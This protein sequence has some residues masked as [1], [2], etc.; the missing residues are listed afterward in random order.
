MQYSKSLV[1]GMLYLELDGGRVDAKGEFTFGLGT[2]KRTA[3]IGADGVHGFSTEVQPPFFEGAVTV[4]AGSDPTKI[5]AFVDGTATLQLQNGEV[6]VLSGACYVGEGS[7][8][9]KESEMGVRFE[10]LR[11]ELI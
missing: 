2:P 1:G 3:I 11:G 6:F 7:V 10:G 4:K 9:T 8:K 5:S